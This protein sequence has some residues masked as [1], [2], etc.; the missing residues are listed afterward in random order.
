MTTVDEEGSSFHGYVMVTN[1][2]GT[3]F[4]QKYVIDF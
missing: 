4:I 3:T 1:I 2:A